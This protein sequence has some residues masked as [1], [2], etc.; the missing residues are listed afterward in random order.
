MPRT[1]LVAVGRI[2]RPHGLGGEVR[3]ESGTG[4]PR[5]LSGYTRF[6][7]GP[8]ERPGVQAG[9]PT[10]IVV[11][12]SRPHGRFM[13]LKFEGISNP[14]SAAQFVH[15]RLYVERADM[16]PLEPGEYYHADLLGCRVTGAEGEELGLVDD[17]F[18]S[19]A[20]DVLVIR[21][22]RR[23]WMLPVIDEYIAD[24]DSEAGEIRVRL[25][26]GGF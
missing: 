23:E 19:G 10:P 18:S 8:P 11:E 21:D 3:L 13:L 22:G 6:Y 2:G 5:G 20:H 12:H 14:E 7:V 1:R 9:E 16:P 24:M 15:S 4:L 17:V 26:E 25:P